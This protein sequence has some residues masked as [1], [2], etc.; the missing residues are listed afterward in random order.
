MF[1]LYEKKETKSKASNGNLHKA[2]QAKN[3]E[4]YT[5]LSDIEKELMHYKP[6]FK[7]KIVYCNCDDPE[8]SN[9]WK[10]F[11]LNFAHLGLKKLIATF[12]HI[13]TSVYKMEYTGGND[14]D[15]SAGTKTP[16]K[17]NGDFRSEE[18]VEILKESDIVVTNP[19]FSLFREYVDQLM[20]YEKKFLIIGNMNS[21]TCKNIFPLVMSNKVWYGASIHSGDRKFNVPDDY[22]LDAAG[23]GLDSNGKKFIKVKGVRWY[24]NLDY[25]KRHEKLVFYKSFNKEDY[26]TYE[27]YRAINVD[28][29]SDIPNDYFGIVGVPISYLDFHCPDQ[30]EIVGASEQCGSGFACGIFEE[31]SKIK[32]PILNGQKKYS[33]IFIRRVVCQTK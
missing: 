22:P 20:E 31:T 32:H 16:L 33:R 18:C 25:S 26:P 3:D 13:G 8:W 23:C 7:D 1:D 24:T 2:K 11:H 6:H 29:Y 9:F 15:I 14:N 12:Y 27:N 5:Q 28:K 17:G 10:Y 21:V 19:P 30:F 4:F